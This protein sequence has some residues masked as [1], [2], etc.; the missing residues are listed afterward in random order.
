MVLSPA[1]FR[2]RGCD[3]CYCT[4]H[5]LCSEEPTPIRK[6]LPEKNVINNLFGW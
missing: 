3:D 5:Q 4:D 2:M 6:E 1:G